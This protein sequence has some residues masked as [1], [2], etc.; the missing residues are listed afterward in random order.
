MATSMP[1]KRAKLR[2]KSHPVRPAHETDIEP[3]EPAD[4]PERHSP[5]YRALVGRIMLRSKGRCEAMLGCGRALGI[6]PHHKYPVSEGGPVLCPEA[7]L[8]WVCRE[9]HAKIHAAKT[10]PDAEARGLIVPLN[11]KD[12]Q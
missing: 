6:D 2:R 4:D 12:S 5:E 1:R 8:L 11:R 9:C 7:W 3:V 10:R